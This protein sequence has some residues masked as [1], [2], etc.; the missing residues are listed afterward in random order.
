MTI[1]RQ[2]TPKTAPRRSRKAVERLFSKSEG[3]LSDWTKV[4]Q[5]G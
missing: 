4:A 2:N 5:N 3:I 1:S